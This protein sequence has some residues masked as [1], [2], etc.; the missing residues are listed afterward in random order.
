MVFD[1]EFVYI[2]VDIDGFL[3]IEPSLNPWDEA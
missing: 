3:Y 2:V 1:F